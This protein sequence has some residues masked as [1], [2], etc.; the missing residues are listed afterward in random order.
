[1]GLHVE[2]EASKDPTY[3]A[4]CDISSLQMSCSKVFTSKYGRGFGLVALLLPEDH[5]LNQP[6][7]VYGI[8]FYSTLMLLAFINVRFVSRIQVSTSISRLII[9][10][11]H[12]CLFSFFSASP[13]CLAPS[14]WATSSTS[15][16]RSCAQSVSPPTWSTL[17]S[18][19][20]ASVS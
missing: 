3:T 18:S 9:V 11:Q 14:T 6:N 16:W 4:L 5:Q 15:S 19:Y 12:F 10:L 20:Q 2:T 1:M 8:F 17:S 13:R 7:S